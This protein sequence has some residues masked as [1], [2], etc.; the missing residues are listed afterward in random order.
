MFE[1]SSEYRAARK[2]FELQIDCVV[3]DDRETQLGLY[4]ENLRYEFPFA[5][6][7]PKL[8]VGRDT[9]RKVMEP[10]WER[11]RQAGIVLEMETCEFHA[12]SETG[13]YLAAF[14]LKA[15]FANGSEPVS[16]PCLQLMRVRAGLIVEMREYFE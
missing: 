14:T 12:T 13:L 8:I 4:A 3:R 6:D 10:I 11:R 15:L 5:K 9:F 16:S 7:R 2:L 1:A